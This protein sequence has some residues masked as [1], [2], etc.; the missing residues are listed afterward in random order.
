[1]RSVAALLTAGVGG[2]LVR[3]EGAVVGEVTPRSLQRALAAGADADTAIV[4]AELF[5]SRRYVCVCV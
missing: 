4:S 3:E 2:V 1:M 5:V